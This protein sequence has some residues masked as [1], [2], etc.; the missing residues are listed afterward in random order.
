MRHVSTMMT[1]MMLAVM[2]A[3]VTIMTMPR[4]GIMATVTVAI[5]VP[6]LAV[7]IVAHVVPLVLQATEEQMPRHAIRDVAGPSFTL[8]GLGCASQAGTRKQRDHQ[9][10]RSLQAFHPVYLLDP[11]AADRSRSVPPI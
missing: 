3:T 1:V 10:S 9:H 2:L 7:T 8:S 6:A 4:S 11:L 5:S